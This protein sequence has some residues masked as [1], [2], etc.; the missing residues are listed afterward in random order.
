[1][2]DEIR[3]PVYKSADAS[4]DIA[5]AMLSA[6]LGEAGLVIAR[7]QIAD[8]LPAPLKPTTTI[9]ALQGELSAWRDRPLSRWFP[10]EVGRDCNVL[11]ECLNDM[12]EGSFNVL[13]K[14]QSPFLKQCVVKLGMLCHSTKKE[15]QGTKTIDVLLHGEAAAADM[16]SCLKGKGAK[17]GQD[18]L[19]SFQKSAWLLKPT[20]QLE[21]SNIQAEVL[22]AIGATPIAKGIGHGG[23][24]SSASGSQASN[25][26][27]GLAS[28]ADYWSLF[29]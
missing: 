17:A 29:G 23:S 26:P 19:D 24:S 4:W 28:G 18:D 20:M 16:L 27:F 15:K 12:A 2:L 7:Q 10:Q 1:M 21:W 8:K 5:V 13:S 3:S 11:L 25:K 22:R 6:F 14:L 9:A